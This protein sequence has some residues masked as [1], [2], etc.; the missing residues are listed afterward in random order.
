M[1][2]LCQSVKSLLY[3]SMNSMISFSGRGG[4]FLRLLA[5]GCFF[6]SL[7]SR[8]H[9]SSY[10]VAAG[11]ISSSSSSSSIVQASFGLISDGSICSSMA[12]RASRN[13]STSR[14]PCNTSYSRI[15]S[16]VADMLSTISLLVFRKRTLFLKK[17]QCAKTC[18]TINLFCTSE[19][20]SN[21]NA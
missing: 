13:V 20:E 19:L 15:L 17:S 3:C 8:F 5:V 7:S 4:N 14:L 1:I 21:K 12:R 18:A 2:S 10:S 11:L 9:K 6:T 16:A